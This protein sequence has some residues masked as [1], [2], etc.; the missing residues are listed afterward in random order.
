M[1]FQ[2]LLL[3]LFTSP[4]RGIVPAN[5]LMNVQSIIISIVKNALKHV[6]Q[7]ADERRKMAAWNIFMAVIEAT[8]FTGLRIFFMIL[9]DHLNSEKEKHRKTHSYSCVV[10]NFVHQKRSFLQQQNE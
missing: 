5:L 8:G 4:G 1:N 6:K 7:C 2:C 10:L 3:F 9:K